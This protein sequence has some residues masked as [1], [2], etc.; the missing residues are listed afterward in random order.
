[1]DVGLLCMHT[2]LCKVLIAAG[3]EVKTELL[4]RK[5]SPKLVTHFLELSIQFADEGL[6]LGNTFMYLEVNIN[7]CV[8]LSLV[9]LA[10][11]TWGSTHF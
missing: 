9:H 3:K 8:L 6:S 7:V 4:P 11:G 5:P 1:M 2:N 10:Q